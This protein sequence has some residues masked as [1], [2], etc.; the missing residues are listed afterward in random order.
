M[1]A[2]A[3]K[4]ITSGFD[5]VGQQ[6]V[7]PGAG[8]AG[9]LGVTVAVWGDGK[10]RIWRAVAPKTDTARTAAILVDRRLRIRSAP[11]GQGTRLV[12][13]VVDPRLNVGGHMLGGFE[14][15]LP[16]ECVL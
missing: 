3:P 10:P 14:L 9:A 2:V 16:E 8:A 6:G 5:D 1:R 13:C 7:G 15:I 4:M 11:V 12:E